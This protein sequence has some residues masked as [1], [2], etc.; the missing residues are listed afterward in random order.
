MDAPSENQTVRDIGK[1]FL[2]NHW[3]NFARGNIWQLVR[4]SP[5]FDWSPVNQSRSEIAKKF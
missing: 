3:G 1:R 4:K 2:H 5:V